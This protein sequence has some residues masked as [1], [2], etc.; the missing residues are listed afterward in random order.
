MHRFFAKTCS[1]LTERVSK[2][3]Y[4]EN[5]KFLD[6]VTIGSGGESLIKSEKTSIHSMFEKNIG[7]VGGS[8]FSVTHPHDLTI[9]KY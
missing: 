3:V 2:C 5:I 9:K 7:R 4:L 6:I 1:F 8:W